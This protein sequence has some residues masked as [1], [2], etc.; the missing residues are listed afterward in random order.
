MIPDLAQRLYLL[1][2]FYM[3]LAELR[4]ARNGYLTWDY[5]RDWWPRPGD[6]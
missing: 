5:R 1:N 4:I 2:P 3:A 6:V